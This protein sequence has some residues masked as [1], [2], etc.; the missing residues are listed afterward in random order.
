LWPGNWKDQLNNV[1]NKIKKHNME[2][3]AKKRQVAS[4]FNKNHWVVKEITENELWTFFGIMVMA[5]VVGQKG[6]MWDNKDPEGIR[7]RVSVDA[8]MKKY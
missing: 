5:R 6:E 8:Y 7:L 3:K 4:I 2:L 1:N